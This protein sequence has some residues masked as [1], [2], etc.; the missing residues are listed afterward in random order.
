MLSNLAKSIDLDV[1][2]EVNEWEVKE[3]LPNYKSITDTLKVN[4]FKS[5][6]FQIQV[7]N[8]FQNIKKLTLECTRFF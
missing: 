3:F 1:H 4:R 8:L 2:D 7:V 6:Y 5:N